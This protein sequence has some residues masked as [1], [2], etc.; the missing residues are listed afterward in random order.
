[1]RNMWKMSLDN[2]DMFLSSCLFLSIVSSTKRG[3]LG[4]IRS[5][6]QFLRF[7]DGLA[8]T[9]AATAL[10]TLN[11][12]KT[13]NTLIAFQNV[14]NIFEHTSTLL[15]MPQDIQNIEKCQGLVAGNLGFIGC[16]HE[17]L[18]THLE[19]IG[20][21]V[22]SKRF[23]RVLEVLKCVVVRFASPC[24]SLVRSKQQKVRSEEKSV[25]LRHDPA[26]PQ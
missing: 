8:A 3:K 23:Q 18:S 13:L 2:L 14:S 15:T 10:C 21:L 11:T 7:F 5:G 20:G 26:T 17:L 4:L 24:F 9:D 12:L 19:F 1:M 6:S 16:C 25:G 22:Q